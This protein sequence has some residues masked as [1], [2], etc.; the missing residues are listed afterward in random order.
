MVA[1]S[2]FS[3]LK[4]EHM[5]FERKSEFSICKLSIRG[6]RGEGV[7]VDLLKTRIHTGKFQM[8]N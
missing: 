1:L 4:Y 2:G 6:V 3:G 7:G 8:T 5:K